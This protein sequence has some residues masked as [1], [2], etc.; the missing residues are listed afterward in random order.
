M[1]LIFDNRNSTRT[2]EDGH[3]HTALDTRALEHRIEPISQVFYTRNAFGGLQPSPILLRSLQSFRAAH[4]RSFWQAV[5]ARSPST[6]FGEFKAISLD[7]NNDDAGRAL[8]L[9]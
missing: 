1:R 8:C 2:H 3:L 4:S 6:L 5:S 7:I 9:G